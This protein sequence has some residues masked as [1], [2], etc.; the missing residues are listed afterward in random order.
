VHNVLKRRRNLTLLESWMMIAF[1]AL[2]A[3]ANLA[4]E[5]KNYGFLDIP[6]YD[7]KL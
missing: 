7:H 3:K 6:S 1:S 4:A 2:T 5:A